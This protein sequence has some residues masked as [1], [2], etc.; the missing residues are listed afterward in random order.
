MPW[1]Y[2]SAERRAKHKWS[3][4]EAGFDPPDIPG[5]PG[6]CPSSVTRTPGLAERLLNDGIPWPPEAEHPE[7]IYN[8]YQ[9]V[10]YRAAPSVPGKIY[11]GFPEKE[12][13]GRLVPDE[14]LGTLAER[15]DNAGEF[16]KFKTWAKKY[17]RQGWNSLNYKP[18]NA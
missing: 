9:G 18:K 12:Q 1:K 6:K 4:D 17:L 3:R 8:V 16:R 14:V 5:S 2:D 11:H 13:P 15:A 7:R 10:V